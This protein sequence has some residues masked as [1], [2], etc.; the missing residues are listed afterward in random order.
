MD[1]TD[2]NQNANAY[3]MVLIDGDGLL[4][5]R[6]IRPTTGKAD[7]IIP[8]SSTKNTYDKAVK[9]ARRQRMLSAVQSWSNMNYPKPQKL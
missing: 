5:S 2:I 9:E 8:H 6:E 7:M 4:V 3:I 1:L